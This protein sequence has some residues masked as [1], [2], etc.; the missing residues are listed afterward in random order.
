MEGEITIALLRANNDRGGR[1]RRMGGRTFIA[2]LALKGIL[3]SFSASASIKRSLLHDYC[4][5]VRFR[6]SLSLPSQHVHFF[7]GWCPGPIRN[8]LE[9]IGKGG[10]MW[11]GI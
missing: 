3:L 7:F 1:K 10:H 9:G 8:R 5:W 6:G 4:L 11:P 2:Y